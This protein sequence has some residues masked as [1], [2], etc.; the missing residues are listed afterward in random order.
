MIPREKRAKQWLSTSSF[1]A[2]GRRK[3]EKGIKLPPVRLIYAL[4]FFQTRRC[5]CWIIKSASAVQRCWTRRMIGTREADVPSPDLP[6]H[7]GRLD[8]MQKKSTDI[9]MATVPSVTYL[10]R[11]HVFKKSIFL[12]IYYLSIYLSN[13]LHRCCRPLFLLPLFTAL[14]KRKRKSDFSS[15]FLSLLKSTEA[16]P[17]MKPGSLVNHRTICRMKINSTQPSAKLILPNFLYSSLMTWYASLSPSFFW[18]HPKDF[19]K[20]A[21]RKI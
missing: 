18:P 21:W 10:M 11:E 12:L 14:T 4:F 8:G 13:Y 7:R 3:S 9:N 1:I 15:H 5:V 19:L 6:Q 16:Q 17:G 20:L 2:V